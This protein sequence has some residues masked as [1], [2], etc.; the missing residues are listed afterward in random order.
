MRIRAGS[1]LTQAL[2]IVVWS[3]LTYMVYVIIHDQI[4]ACISVEYFTVGHAPVFDTQDRTLLGLGWGVLAAWWVDLLLEIPLATLARIGN[5]PKYTP[6]SLIR[7]VLLLSGCSAVLAAASGVTALV[8]ATN[9][10]ISL[11]PEMSSRLPPDKHT[12]FLVDLWI[13]K[14]SYTGG[15]VDG[16][17]VMGWVWRMRI[18]MEQADPA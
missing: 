13:H 7:P 11:H 17:F 18:R 1:C 12:P 3:M 10:W 16:T 4:T 14:A 5:R 2:L 15:F 8:L 6:K 9:G